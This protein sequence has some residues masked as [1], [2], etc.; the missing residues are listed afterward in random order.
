MGENDNSEI[1]KNNCSLMVTTTTTTAGS[2]ATTV[3]SEAEAAEAA[4]ATDE[5]KQVKTNN[6]NLYSNNSIQNCHSSQFSPDSEFHLIK[7]NIP[8]RPKIKQ[9]QYRI[10]DEIIKLQNIFNDLKTQ[11]EELIKKLDI[12]IRENNIQYSSLISSE[13]NGIR[14]SSRAIWTSKIVLDTL[15]N[16]ICNISSFKDLVEKLT[17]SL[18]VMKSI[19]SLLISHIRES[20][21]EFKN[22]SDLLCDVLFN[23]GQ[24]GGS[25]INFKIAN[26]AAVDITDDAMF[27][28]E[29][30]IKIEFLP[31][32][33]M[34][35]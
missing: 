18:T 31:I 24:L 12:S 7:Y 11:D 8:L 22:I 16:Q 9:I 20:D 34:I 6:F 5:Y 15:H 19:R 3:M 29:N 27:K 13:L 14:K 1:L 28:A 10:S 32:P 35:T 23:A 17:P 33:K 30:K 25:L 21:H 2:G 4:E 26:N